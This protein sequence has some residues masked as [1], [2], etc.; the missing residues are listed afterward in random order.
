[1]CGIMA[2]IG[3]KEVKLKEILESAKFNSYRGDDGIGV[4]YTSIY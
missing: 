4:L 3:N 2:Y 1:M